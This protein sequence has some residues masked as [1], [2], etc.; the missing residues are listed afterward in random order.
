MLKRIKADLLSARKSKDKFTAG[1]LGALVSEGAMI[2]KNYGD[3]ETTDAEMQKLIQKFKKGVLDT[4]EILGCQFDKFSEN[5]DPM[6]CTELSMEAE[7]YDKY[8]P[9]QLTD[10]EIE[11]EIGHYLQLNSEKAN[12]G[13]IMGHFK[14]NFD[15]RYDGKNLARIVNEILKG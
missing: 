5:R 12:I 8:L 15:G 10:E 13:S 6:K 2:G 3:R 4:M 14:K 1:I 11:K 7:I 9:T